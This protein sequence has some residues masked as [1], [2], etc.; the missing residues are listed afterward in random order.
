MKQLHIAFFNRSFYPDTA[1]TGQLLTELCESLVQEHGCRVSVVAG[2]PL[3]PAVGD[4]ADASKGIVF[5][6]Q[7]HRGIEILRARGTRFSK[8][9]FLGRFSNYA[10]YFLSAC[11]AGL[12]LDRPDVVVA[13]TDPPIIGLAAYLASRRSGVPFVMSY[14]DIFPEVAR[15]LEDFQSE[16]VN[17]VLHGVNRFLVQKADRIVALGDTMRQRLI[18]GKGAAPAKSVIIPDWTDCSEITPGSKRNPFSLAH[19]LADKFVVMHSGNMGLSQGL[20][21][22]VQAAARLRD[23]PNIH[24][25]FIGEGV[26]KPA[27]EGEVQALGLR[28][29]RFLPYQPKERLMESFAT[30]DVFIVSLKQGLAGYIVPSKLY[31]ILAAGRPYVAA[32][33]EACEAA[34]IMKKY[35]CGLLAKPGDPEDLTQ[36]ILT[37]YHDRA[38]ATRLGTNA[39]RAALEFDRPRQVR[40]YYELFRELT[41]TPLPTPESR[42]PLLK[43][44]FDLLVSGLGLLASA[45]LWA[46]IAL[47]IK[48]DDGGP[49]FYAHERV[50]KGGRRFK[51][52]KFRSMFADSDRRFGPLQARDR[53][54]RITRVGRFLR[55]TAQDE[56][57][58][59]WNIFKGD[60]SFVG[61][62]ALLP[63]EIEVQD[64]RLEGA[65]GDAVAM[66]KI[67][68]YEARHRVRPGLTGLAQVYAPRDIPRRHKFK[69]D[70]L[71]IKNQSFWLDLK[72]IALSFWITFRGKWES[73]DKRFSRHKL[74]P[75]KWTVRDAQV[76]YLRS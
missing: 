46:L 22:V 56:L 9:Q 42:P 75:S 50:G 66:E 70:L 52:W 14:R 39:R 47:A 3:L 62:R 40:A 71:Y 67:S 27:L 12:R 60:M 17:T 59:L 34:A 65:N 58:Q 6:R 33:E 43:R 2:V 49:V 20:G 32:V 36:K 38:L 24:M 61:P 29:V 72:L 41:R 26:K 13:L 45:P 55:G 23:F 18:D 37:L 5:H 19:G 63:E 11:Y 30:A 69:L 10:S 16:T 25:V 1:A 57:P 74:Q 73:R 21:T 15:L 8:R 48:L 53:D 28:N 35:E 68:G 7:Q 51:S 31:G 54:P 44:P 76:R 64:S 4:G